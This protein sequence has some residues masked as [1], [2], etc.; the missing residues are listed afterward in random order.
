M[1]KDIFIEGNG[2][3]F[4]AVAR[5]GLPIVLSL[6]FALFLLWR[7]DG[8]LTTLQAAA[9]KQELAMNQAADDMKD[10][11]KLDREERRIQRSL[12]LQVC[13]NTSPDELTRR[14]C[15]RKAE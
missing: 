8:A 9:V 7:L 14:E 6:L 13:L 1:L 10:F 2:G 3:L 12:F 15:L 11:V 5:L 4:G